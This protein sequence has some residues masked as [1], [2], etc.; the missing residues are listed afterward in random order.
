MQKSKNRNL[1]G[2][3]QY[4]TQCRQLK[5]KNPQKNKTMSEAVF[6]TPEGVKYV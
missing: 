6:Q 3:N 5:G 1:K 2:L 4:A